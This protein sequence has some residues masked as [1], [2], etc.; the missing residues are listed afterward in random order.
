M[1]IILETYAGLSEVE[2][3]QVTT[4]DVVTTADAARVIS[5]LL[6]RE[7]VVGSTDPRQVATTRLTA[8]ELIRQVV[9]DK[10]PAPSLTLANMKVT[11]AVNIGTQLGLTCDQMVMSLCESAS[12]ADIKK[13]TNPEPPNEHKI[14]KMD[15]ARDLVA[16]NPEAT[17]KELIELMQEALPGSSTVMCRTYIYNIRKALKEA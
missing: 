16:A 3:L 10:M 12:K 1:N 13:L 7:V 15:I 9:V 17:T 14:T 4:K 11:E 5:E 8:I 2:L 6:G